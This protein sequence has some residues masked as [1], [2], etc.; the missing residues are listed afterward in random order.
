VLVLPLV[1]E[2]QVRGVLE[3]ASLGGFNPAHQAFLEQLT[4]SIGIVLN[5][6]EANMRTEGLLQQSQSLAQQ[7]QTRQEELQ[8]TNEELQ[9]KA[10]RWPSRTR[11]SS[12]RTRRSSRPARRSRE[13]AKQLALTSKYKSEFLA[14]MSHEL[15]HAAQQ[16]AHPVDQ[17]SKNPEGT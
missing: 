2:G 8:N 4:E 11:R 3:L 9:E 7:L 10:R 13:K 14:N 6:I 1:F 15:R 17:L 5:T 16:P 12:G